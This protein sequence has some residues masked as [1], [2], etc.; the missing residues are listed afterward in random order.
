[1]F[2]RSSNMEKGIHKRELGIEEKQTV[3]CWRMEGE[4]NYARIEW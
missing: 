1:M 3:F 2:G 4:R